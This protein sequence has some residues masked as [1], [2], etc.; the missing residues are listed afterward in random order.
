MSAR[1]RIRKY[2][3]E[4]AAADLSRVEVLVAPRDREA[5]LAFARQLRERHRLEKQELESLIEEA[6]SK[7]GVRVLD[8]IDLD[9]LSNVFSRAEVVANALMERGDARAFALG[10]KLI[11]RIEAGERNGSH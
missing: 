5:V 7:Y 3:R 4:G 10:R 2:R 8:N 11:N 6:L 1:D 9:R